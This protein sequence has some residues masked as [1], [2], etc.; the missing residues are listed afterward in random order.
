[1][2]RRSWYGAAA[3]L[4]FFCAFPLMTM[5][6]FQSVGDIARNV[7]DVAE[8]DVIIAMKQDFLS[9]VGG[10]DVVLM[11]LIPF[12]VLLGAWSGLSWLHF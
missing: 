10:G 9:Y 12:I 5:L 8:R 2:K 11:F 7:Q 1:M 6:R 4:G 3:F